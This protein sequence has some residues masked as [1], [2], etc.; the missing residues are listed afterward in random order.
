MY[1]V[2]VIEDRKDVRENIA[3]ILTEEGYAVVT[4]ENGVD[5]VRAA[6]EAPPDIIVCDIL[7]P[8]LDGYQVLMEL[9]NRPTTAKIPF[10]FLTAKA[11]VQ[12]FRQGLA[13]GSDAYLTK[14][15]KIDELLSTI[16]THLA[17]KMMGADRQ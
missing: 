4:T 11:S 5:G 2:L 12:D 1:T 6:L 10:I 16:E 9:R 8:E 15:F 3:Q 14:P 13:L 7:M 17:S